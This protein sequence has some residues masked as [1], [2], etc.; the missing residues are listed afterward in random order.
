MNSSAKE[1]ASSMIRQQAGMYGEQLEAIWHA[2]K[3]SDKLV[4]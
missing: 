1:P 2:K 3:A 4:S